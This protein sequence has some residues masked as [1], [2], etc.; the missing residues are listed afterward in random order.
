M[1]PEKF[2]YSDM[3]LLRSILAFEF[4]TENYVPCS[5]ELENEPVFRISAIRLDLKSIMVFVPLL[6]EAP[7]LANIFNFF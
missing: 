2:I 7:P 4:S 1:I 3:A 6:M 5:F